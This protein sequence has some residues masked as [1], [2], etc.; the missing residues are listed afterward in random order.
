MGMTLGFGQGTEYQYFEVPQPS[1]PMAQLR[2]E[3]LQQLREERMRRQQRRIR[4]GDVTAMFPWKDGKPDT[5][6][7]TPQGSV[8][9]GSQEAPMAPF[10]PSSPPQFSPRISLPGQPIDEAKEIVP[11]RSSTMRPQGLQLPKREVATGAAL[12]PAAASAQDTG[13]LQKVRVGRAM[14]ILTIAFVA[15]RVLGILR[16]SMF[17]IVFGTSNISD[18]YLQAFLVPDLIF[19]IVSGGALSSAFI[20]VFTN[21]MVSENDQSKAWRIASSALNLAIA[22]MTIFAALGIIFARQLVPLYNA[23]ATSAQLDL[24]ASLTRIMLLQ[25]VILGSGVIVTSILNAQQDFKLSAIGSVLY[26]VG[27]IGGLLPGLFFY[28]TGQNNTIFAVYAATWGVVI[29]ALVQV[30]VQVPGMFKVGMKYTRSFDWKDPGII[31]IAKQMGPRIGNSAMVYLSTFVDRDLIMLVVGTAGGGVTQYYQ[32]FQLVLL[33]YGIFGLSPATAVFPTLAENISKGRFDRVRSTIL[34][35]LRSILYTT[36]PSS[37]GLIILGL[38]VIQVLLQ[39]GHYNFES[40][41]STYF[42]LAAFSIGL[43]GLCVVELLTRSF[44]AMRDTKTPVIVSIAQFIF[45]IALSLILVNAAVWGT[46]WGLAGLAFS[47]SAANILEAV[48]LFWLLDQ[49]IGDMQPKALL[50]FIGRVLLASLVMAVAVFVVRE[51]LDFV[52][53]TTNRQSTGVLGTIEVIIK[54]GIEV[55]VALFVYIRV[56][57]RIGVQELGSFKRILDRLKLSWI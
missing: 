1:Q 4:G 37:I 42:P 24:I 26:N 33:P 35:T 51:V 48:V 10:S 34:D 21:Y 36:I 50:V 5:Q 25:S 55:F 18:A 9:S 52:L 28:L 17:A 56:S 3:R 38:P 44:Y 11:V 19:N 45:K 53:N 14:S 22:M 15:S 32:A 47:T 40:A 41:Q 13:M 2:Q 29:G 16:S 30:G 46:R 23:G 27:L 39:H 57:R 49:R 31:Q 8:R 7:P 12:Q 20:P 6:P 54:L 43:A